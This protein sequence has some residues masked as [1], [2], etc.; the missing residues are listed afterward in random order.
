MAKNIYEFMF[1]LDQS[2]VSTDVPAAVAQL[3]GVFEKYGCEILAS[4]PWSDQQRLAY[5]IRNQKKGLYYL[6]YIRADSLKM[7]EIEGDFK[8]FESILR[9]MPMYIEKK[10]EEQMLAV[11]K[12][13]HALA[14]QV[15]REDVGDIDDYGP[16]RR[17]HDKD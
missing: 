16:P 1:I 15:A 14:L 8:L 10:W 4:R 6:I 3:H 13:E 5:P 11:A 7:T 9:M 12:D 2:K 17:S